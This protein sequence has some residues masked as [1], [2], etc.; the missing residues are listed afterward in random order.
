MD[1]RDT[2]EEGRFRAELRDWLDENLPPERRAMRGGA[3]RFDD[4]FGREWSRE[5]YDA[6]YAGL[7][8][9]K[10]DGGADDHGARD[11]GPQVTPP[12]QDPLRRGDLVPGVL[13]ARRRLRPR[14][15]ADAGR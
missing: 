9:P 12:R 4:A 5:L 10:E 14:G 8:W 3:Q 6:G 2:A 1:L 13:G 7:T 11:R 15:R